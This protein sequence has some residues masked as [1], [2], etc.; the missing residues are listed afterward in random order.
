VCLS[1]EEARKEDQGSLNFTYQADRKIAKHHE[2]GLGCEGHSQEGAAPLK[3]SCCALC[4][5]WLLE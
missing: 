2:T 5:V 4:E 3:A 1:G